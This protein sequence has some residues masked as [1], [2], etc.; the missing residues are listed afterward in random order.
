M[1]DPQTPGRGTSPLSSS[2]LCCLLPIGLRANGVALDVLLCRIGMLQ[3]RPIGVL[4]FG[5]SKAIMGPTRLVVVKVT[6]QKVVEVVSILDVRGMAIAWEDLK[7]YPGYQMLG[8][9]SFFQGIVWVTATPYY[10]GGHLERCQ[11]VQAS[12]VLVLAI[13]FEESGV[14]LRSPQ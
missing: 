10:E 12:P 4:E 8:L 14:G 5:A 6:K 11:L 1:G 9:D 13:F 3:G 2:G 7:A